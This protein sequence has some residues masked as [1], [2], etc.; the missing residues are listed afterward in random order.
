MF[1]RKLSC[2]TPWAEHRWQH[3]S[4]QTISSS[5]SVS[6]L[7]FIFLFVR[8]YVQQTFI[9]I[10]ERWEIVP[11]YATSLWHV[12]ICTL[13]NRRGRWTQNN[14]REDIS[15]RRIQSKDQWDAQIL[16]LCDHLSEKTEWDCSNSTLITKFIVNLVASDS[17]RNTKDYW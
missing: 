3:K 4:S 8:D 16:R 17:S 6:S 13:Y 10:R 14:R 7:H 9:S 2:R 5:S 11:E 12:D 15:I 1:H